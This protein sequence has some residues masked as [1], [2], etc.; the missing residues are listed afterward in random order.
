MLGSAGS[1]RTIVSFGIL[2]IPVPPESHLS[3]LGD[4]AQML[5]DLQQANKVFAEGYRC[6]I[7]TFKGNVAISPCRP[8]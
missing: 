6:L 3:H 4:S 1:N 7:S 5:L 8:L 2:C